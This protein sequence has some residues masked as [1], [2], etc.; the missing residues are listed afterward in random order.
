MI[1]IRYNNYSPIT[2]HTIIQFGKTALDYAREKNFLEIIQLLTPASTAKQVSLITITFM[3]YV[4]V[5]MPN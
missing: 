1:I 5:A 2:V 4:R 3:R